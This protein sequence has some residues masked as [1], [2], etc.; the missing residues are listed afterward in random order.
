MNSWMRPLQRV[1]TVTGERCWKGRTVA[2]MG[3]C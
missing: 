3:G 2:V 1:V